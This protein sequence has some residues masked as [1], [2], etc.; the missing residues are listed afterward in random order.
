MTACLASQRQRFSTDGLVLVPSTCPPA[1]EG[2]HGSVTTSAGRGRWPG[3]RMTNRLGSLRPCQGTM[4]QS[5]GWSGDTPIPPTL[6]AL[7]WSTSP[8]F[9]LSWS[10]GPAVVCSGWAGSGRGVTASSGLGPPPPPPLHGLPC[11]TVSA[12]V[13]HR[14]LELE[15]KPAEMPSLGLVMENGQALP[16]FLLCSTLLVIKMYAVGV[17]TG[18]TRLRKKVCDLGCV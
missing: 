18:Y 8:R 6:P 17:I 4:V 15:P 16:A 14:V 2:G 11:G 12:S 10:R 13:S 3:V 7:T 9:L 1:S 5:Q